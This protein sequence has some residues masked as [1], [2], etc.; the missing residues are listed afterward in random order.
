MITPHISAKK[1]DFAKIVLMPGDPLRAKHIA[2][3][4]LDNCR[5]VNNIRGMLGYT[6]LYKKYP[7]SIMS[8][9]IGIPSCSI[10]A[11]ELIT[12][13]EVKKIIR[14]GTCG[15]VQPNINVRDIIIG[16]GACTDSN[17]NRIRFNGHDFS[18]IA[19]FQLV[20][21]AVKAAKQLGLIVYVGNLFTTD[22]FYAPNINLFNIL[23]KYNILGIE[24]EAAGLYAIAAE[25]DAKA[26][27]I[28]TVSD[29]LNLH[30]KKKYI[31]STAEERQNSFNEMVQI[32]LESLLLDI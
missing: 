7:I 28:C 24:M 25:F 5:L 27:T 23:E 4:F 16:M 26:L 32:A 13:Y 11:K 19:D 29:K 20:C 30:C 6:G 8:H 9:G 1:G 2:E 22:L 12:E 31:S 15:T 17:I 18:A 14:V 3:I 10:Y 21:N